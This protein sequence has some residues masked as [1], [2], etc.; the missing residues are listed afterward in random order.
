MVGHLILVSKVSVVD[1]LNKPVLSKVDPCL[2]SWSSESSHGGQ[3]SIVLVDVLIL[4]CIGVCVGCSEQSLLMLKV[5][6]IRLKTRRQQTG[7]FRSFLEISN[8]GE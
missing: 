4:V 3:E 1:V 5:V 6:F 2:R 8:A 7:I